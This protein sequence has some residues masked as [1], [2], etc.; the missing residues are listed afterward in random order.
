[1][2]VNPNQ[3]QLGV[4]PKQIVDDWNVHCA[5]TAGSEYAAWPCRIENRL[6]GAKLFK[7]CRPIVDSF[8]RLAASR[9]RNTLQWGVSRD[10]L[11]CRLS[12]AWQMGGSPRAL[13][14]R[15]RQS[16]IEMSGTQFFLPWP[17]ST[18]SCSERRC[19]SKMFGLA[20]QRRQNVIG[21]PIAPSRQ[22]AQT[23]FAC[24]HVSQRAMRRHLDKDFF[25]LADR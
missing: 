15:K 6:R 12:T 18:R 11:G 10:D 19:Q 14:L 9:D 1:M 8:Q 5:I 4:L 21:C 24:L 20:H 25:A 13:P 7:N 23:F 17:A 16:Q 2:G 22:T 3:S